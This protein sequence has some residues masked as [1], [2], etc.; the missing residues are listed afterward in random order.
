LPHPKKESVEPGDI[1]CVGIPIRSV[2]HLVEQQLRRL[3]AVNLSLP[4][5]KQGAKRAGDRR[6]EQHLVPL[7][8]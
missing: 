7:R 5:K 6:K 3:P 2:N 8:Q 4:P 1:T